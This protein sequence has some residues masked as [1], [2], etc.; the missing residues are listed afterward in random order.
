MRYGEFWIPSTN[1]INIIIGPFVVLLDPIFYTN[2]KNKQYFYFFYIKT[3]FYKQYLQNQMDKRLNK[4][5]TM[6]VFE[7]M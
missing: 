4:Y 2:L 1:C 7:H 6:V 3:D 5:V